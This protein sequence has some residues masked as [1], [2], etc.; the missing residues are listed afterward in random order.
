MRDPRRKVSEAQERRA[1]ERFGARRHAGSG[2]GAKR[3][4]MHT[5]TATI[6]CK[7]VLRGNK[8]ITIQADYL[9][10]LMYN[11]A[12]TGTIP[13]LYITIDGRDWVMLPEADYEGGR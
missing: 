11:A 12:L 9:R 5:E 3:N 8:Q 2:S 1:A 13:F 10:S 4:D 6:E 7:T